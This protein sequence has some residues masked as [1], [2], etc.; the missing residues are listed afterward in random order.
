MSSTSDASQVSSLVEQG[1]KKLRDKGDKSGAA[2]NL[3]KAIRLDPNHELAWLWMSGVVETEPEQV[4]CLKRVL[5][6][7]P[8][9]DAANNGLSILGPDTTPALP[10]ASQ[11]QNSICKFPGCDEGVSKAGHTLCHGHWTA[12]NAGLPTVAGRRLPASK[13]NA[14]DIG[15]QLGLSS[16]KVNRVLAELG[17]IGKERK[18]WV[19][20][21]LGRS[22]G[23]VQKEFEQTGKPFVTWPSSLLSHKLLLD[24]VQN[25]KGESQTENHQET[26]SPEAFHDRYSATLRTTDGH[27]VRSRAEM[28]IDN[29]FYFCGIAHA[30]ERK[31]PIAEEARCD[32]YLPEGKVYVEYWGLEDSPKYAA[33]KK[34]KLELYRKYKF[35]LIELGDEEIKNLDDYLPKML[36]KFGVEVS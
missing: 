10:S 31:L 32:F 26:T 12:L 20:T 19:P 13:L 21:P 16:H 17:W 36:L 23:G 2:E 29:W 34:V 27:W 25:I 30:Y 8:E 33:R 1:I 7:N 5:A 18:G 28:V 4:Y 3:A 9:N 35:N 6:I 14:T 22:L 24:T 11:S 15:N